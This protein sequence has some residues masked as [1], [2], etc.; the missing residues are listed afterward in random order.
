MILFAKL[1]F[2]HNL[3]ELAFILWNP[4]SAWLPSQTDT[5]SK[6]SERLVKVYSSDFLSELL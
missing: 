6:T 1:K 2:E 4:I 5:S 3:S